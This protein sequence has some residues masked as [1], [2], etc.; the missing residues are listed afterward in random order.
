[1]RRLLLCLLGSTL[2]YVTAVN[3][4]SFNVQL[5]DDSARFV[6]ATEVFGGQY[7]P[8]DF[9]TGIFFNEEDDVMVHLGLLVRNDTLD[10]PI[11][12]SIGSR[13]YYADAGNAANQTDSTIAAITIGG[14]LLFIPDTLGGLGFGI[15]YFVAPS[16]VSFLDADGFTEYGARIDYAITEQASIYLGYQKIEAELEIDGSDLKIHSGSFFG[17]GL[18]F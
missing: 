13:L 11:V 18:R 10:N 5:S 12:I 7:G 14:E 17:I 2:F 16:I 4:D 1:M 3:A 9:E 6:Y 15:Y 8:V